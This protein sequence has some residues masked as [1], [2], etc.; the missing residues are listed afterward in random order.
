M[1]CLRRRRS[2][3]VNVAQMLRITD[4][5]QHLAG[6]QQPLG[7]SRPMTEGIQSPIS[8]DG[9]GSPPVA[10]KRSMCGAQ[11]VNSAP[12]QHQLKIA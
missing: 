3:Q 1:G 8:A 10:E 4:R 12:Q 6:V 7:A 2:H 5:S 11:E 9:L